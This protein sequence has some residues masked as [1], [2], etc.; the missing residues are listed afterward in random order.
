[1]HCLHLCVRLETV[2]PQLPPYS[3]H[4]ESPEGHTRMQHP[5]LVAP[6]RPRVEGAGDPRGLPC[7]VGVHSG[8]EAEGA[9]VGEGERF[10]LGGEFGDDHDGAED[11][12]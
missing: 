12:P 7:V 1:M 2:R 8:G 10:G 5:I 6:H 3:A 9:R 11:L 4:L